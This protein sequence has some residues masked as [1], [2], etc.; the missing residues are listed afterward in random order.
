MENA[1]AKRFFIL[2]TG[3]AFSLVGSALVQFSIMLWLADVYRSPVL[4][5]MAA[6]M[7]IVP[8]VI[9]TPF[10]GAYVDRL[11]RRRVMIAA[12]G[13]TALATALLMISYALGTIDLWQVFAVLFFRSTMQGF[14]WPAMQASTSLMVPQEHLARISGL[15]QTVAGASSILSPVLGA[16]LYVSLPMAWVLS[17]DL[18]TAALAIG[19]LLIVQ[20]PEVR[21]VASEGAASVIAEL[22]DAFSY[23][24]S[25]KGIITLLAIFSMVNFLINPAITLFPLLTLEY[26][27]KGPYDVG[28]IEAMAGVG[29]IVG[30][31]TLSIWGGGSR[32]IVTCMAALIGSG[33]SALVIGLLTKD[34]FMVAVL[35][36][37]VLALTI[38]IINGTTMA[39]LQKG[40]RPDMQGRV[41]ALISAISAGM[42][43]LGLILAG[44]I[45][46]ILG[47]QFWFVA[48]GLVMIVM[49]AGSFFLPYVMRLED[50]AVDVVPLEPVPPA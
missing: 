32:K 49:G 22:K 29:M 5:T 33:A 37:I 35:S 28:L 50:R 6:I 17:V 3:Q 25:W 36:T 4:L 18:I 1:W 7:G 20:I 21:K 38:A 12:D 43:P 34:L 31:V 23:I 48:G 16:L 27:G 44:P 40:I 2:W 26:F 30:G 10:A 39:V 24:R 13:L 42:S 14:Q 8:Q 47:I 15:N 41:F 9:L 46:E 45:A 19:V 11:N